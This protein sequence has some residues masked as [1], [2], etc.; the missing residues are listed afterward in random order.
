MD[1]L[2]PLEEEIV[3]NKSVESPC[4][5]HSHDH[6]IHEHTHVD[7]SGPGQWADVKQLA[8]GDG[9]MTVLDTA[10]VNGEFTEITYNRHEAPTEFDV[11][12]EEVNLTNFQLQEFSE[13]KHVLGCQRLTSLTLRQNRLHN[14]NGIQNLPKSCAHLDLYENCLTSEAVTPI[15]SLPQLEWLDLSFNTLRQVPACLS[16]LTG[17]KDLFLISNKITE[18][19]NVAWPKLR[20]LELGDNR[21]REISG[22]EA[23][24][25]LD[26]LYLGRNKITSIKCLDHLSRLRILSLQSNRIMSTVGLSSLV[27]L[28][29]LY[30]SHNGISLIEG[31]STLIRLRVLDVGTNRLTS[32]TGCEMLAGL[33]ELWANSNALGANSEEAFAVLDPLLELPKLGTVYLEHNPLQSHPD[34]RLLIL[35]RLPRLEQLDALLV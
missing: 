15:A 33:E 17:L 29:E 21:I 30:L 20:Q 26:Q 7:R 5:A 9:K 1:D 3:S 13:V 8:K 12:E 19:K 23:L 27:M 10:R 32:L 18:I 11:D 16:S 35:S 2:P 14:L 28:E 34:Y 6:V 31:L 25:E 24:G 22:L 4:C